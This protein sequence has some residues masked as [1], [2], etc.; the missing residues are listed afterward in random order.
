VED[1]Q[2]LPADAEEALVQVFDY[3]LGRQAQMVFTSTAGPRQLGKLSPRLVSR[4]GSGLLAGLEPY[5]AASRLVLLQDKAQHRQLAVS[6]DILTWLADHLNGGGRQLDGALLQL[7]TL[8]RLHP[9]LDLATAVDYFRDQAYA[10]RPTIDRITQ[11]VGGYFRVQPGQLR[12]QRRTRQLSLPRQVGMYLTRQLTGLSL[13]QIGTY[14]GGRDHS[15]VLHACQK[16]E[17][18][19]ACDATFSGAVRQLHAELA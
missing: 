16:V 15:T 17:Q 3:R 7:E 5:Q 6:G 9:C 8:A 1:L 14:F 10:S 12:S 4:L 18:V 2:H 19:L 13:E 11:Q